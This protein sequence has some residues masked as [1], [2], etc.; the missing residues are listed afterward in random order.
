M[1][2]VYLV[3]QPG[4]PAVAV[5][6]SSLLRRLLPGLLSSLSDLSDG[7]TGREVVEPSA[8]SGLRKEAVACPRGLLEG[9]EMR[10]EYE[11]D[12]PSNRALTTSWRAMSNG[13][14]PSAVRARMLAPCLISSLCSSVH[15]SCMA[16]QQ[17]RQRCT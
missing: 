14:S 4:S 8:D 13:A 5:A 17:R 9:D 12:F 7:G 15:S 1:A 11:G 2:L 10:L 16:L 3:S 6:A